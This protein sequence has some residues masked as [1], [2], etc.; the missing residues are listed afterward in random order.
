MFWYTLGARPDQSALPYARGQRAVLVVILCLNLLVLG[1]SA[2]GAWLLWQAWQTGQ[3]PN[4]HLFWMSWDNVRATFW[5]WPWVVPITYGIMRTRSGLQA[6]RRAA[7][8]GDERIMPLASE[9][10]EPLADGRLLGEANEF[11]PFPLDLS[12][13]RFLLQL[14]AVELMVI[15]TSVGVIG[16]GLGIWLV[17]DPPTDGILLA[18]AVALALAGTL[19]LVAGVRLWRRRRL[20]PTSGHFMADHTGLRWIYEAPHRREAYIPWQEVQAFWMVSWPLADQY[21]SYRASYVLDSGTRMMS[22]SLPK[23]PTAAQLADH[24]RLCR[25]V[26]MRTGLPLRDCSAAVAA[27]AQARIEGRRAMRALVSGASLDV[28]AEFASVV[29][30]H[31]SPRAARWLLAIE[32]IIVVL[33]AAVYGGGWVLQRF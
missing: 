22:W 20:W 27:I 3:A 11:G 1:S 14:A 13:Q 18:F 28:P 23:V 21:T 24:L 9:Q 32:L 19:M 5:I 25:L 12:V 17:S 10:P 33:F 15:G 26:V 6:A 29:L 4:W 2:W 8:A 16:I 31:K 30:G 7:F